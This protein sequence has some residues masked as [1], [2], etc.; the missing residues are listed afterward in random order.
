MAL[1]AAEQAELAQ[2]EKEVGSQ[3]TPQSKGLSPQE[4]MELQS[5]EKEVGHLAPKEASVPQTILEHGANGAALGY[6]PQMQAYAQPAIYAGLNAITGRD[7]P[8]DSYVTARDANI[9]RMQQ[10]QEANPKTALA[11]QVGGSVVGALATPIPGGAAKSVLGGLLKGAGYGAAYGG[12][13]NPGDTEGVVDP[14][15]LGERGKNALKGAAIGGVTGAG[16]QLASKALTGLAGG[17]RNTA[18]NQAVRS[19]GAMLKD[20]RQLEGKDQTGKLGRYML[21]NGLVRMGDTVDSIADKAN[22]RNTVAGWGLKD[23]Y[24]AADAASKS[25]GMEAVAGFN[26]VKDKSAILDA[27]DKQLGNS[28]GKASAL[29]RV[30]NYLDQLAADHGDQTLPP[31]VANDIKGSLDNVINYERN[32]LKGSPVAEQAFKSGRGFLADKIGSQVGGLTGADATKRLQDTNLDWGM[33][34]KVADMASDYSNRDSAN[35]MF[36][37]HDRIASGVGSVAGAGAGYAAGDHDPIHEG[38]FGVG[39]ALLGLLANKAGRTYG[40]AIMARSADI[41]SKVATP[42]DVALQPAGNALS[43]Q[44]ALRALIE[45]ERLGGK[46][47]KKK[48]LDSA[49]SIRTAQ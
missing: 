17:L 45:K 27:I 44:A 40:P 5:L 35:H 2:L 38:G 34:K 31:S 42:L 47:E 30:S 6:L 36:G 22:A 49:P 15:Q 14:A 23:I 43:S 25:P 13:S 11:S 1:S 12:L 41:A 28:E 24:G 26:P 29:S 10:Q 9:K 8:T 20:F 16:T 18:E 46:L 37:L 39:G 48:E 4:Q 33:S 21:D 19:G 7:V 3:A 32:P